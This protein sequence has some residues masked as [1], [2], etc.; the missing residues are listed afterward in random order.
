[1][2]RLVLSKDKGGVRE[3]VRRTVCSSP[4]RMCLAPDDSGRGK[5]SGCSLGIF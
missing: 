3:T 5:R 1:M 4:E 2:L